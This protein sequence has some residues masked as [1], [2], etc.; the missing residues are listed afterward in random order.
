[1]KKRITSTLLLFCAV[2]FLLTLILTVLNS[3]VTGLGKED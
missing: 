3:K 1:M 2:L